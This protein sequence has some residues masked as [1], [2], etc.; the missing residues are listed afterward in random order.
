MGKRKAYKR[1]NRVV[2]GV[3]EQQ[4]LDCSA[5]FAA[6]IEFFGKNNAA[7]DGILP[8]CKSCYRKRQR[9]DYHKYHAKRKEKLLITPKIKEYERDLECKC[10][11]CH[12]IHYINLKYRYLG[13]MPAKYICEKCK[14]LQKYKLYEEV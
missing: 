8:Y 12:K 9:R 7:I 1:K 6:T 5:W 3:K 10:P 4:C 2:D 11:S 13:K 14:A